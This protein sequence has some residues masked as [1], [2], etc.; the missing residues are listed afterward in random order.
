MMLHSPRR[1]DN[2]TGNNN[3][4]HNHTIDT[5]RA[6][7]QQQSIAPANDSN[8]HNS[9]SDSDTD[10]HDVD[11]DTPETLIPRDDDDTDLEPWSD[12]IR[13]CTHDVEQQIS[14]IG[15]EDWVTQQRR[16]KWRWAQR[17]ANNTSNKWTIR[18]L[19]WDPTTIAR[20]NARRRQARP[21]TRWTDDINQH[22]QKHF[23]HD[24]AN[25]TLNAHTTN[26]R[27]HDDEH[28]RTRDVD[29]ETRTYSNDHKQHHDEY[30]NVIDEIDDDYHDW[31][32]LAQQALVW[33]DLEET[34]VRRM[35]ERPSA[36]VE[37]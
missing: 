36:T 23:H 11:S 2:T 12:W 17:V 20:F 35:S 27:S 28:N 10:A 16:R 18:A 9:T 29:D 34:F 6:D 24:N 19:T 3:D 1:R 13:R 33:Q 26:S 22:I 37:Y 15:I 25:T 32:T 30:S 8:E 4:T 5:S 31:V 14:N 21:R 7:P